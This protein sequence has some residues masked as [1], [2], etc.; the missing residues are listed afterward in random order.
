[1]L[2]CVDC[3][4]ISRIDPRDLARDSSATRAYAAFLVELAARI[5]EVMLPTISVLLPF[6]DREVTLTFT[7]FLAV[8][9]KFVWW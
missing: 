7:L 3:R 1:M 5:P 8:I 6:L 2:W 4:E 9:E